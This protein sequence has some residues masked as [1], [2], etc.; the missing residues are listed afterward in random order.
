MVLFNPGRPKTTTGSG[1]FPN[2]ITLTATKQEAM[3][4]KQNGS[5]WTYRDKMTNVSLQNG[6]H[7]T[8]IF[9]EILRMHLNLNMFRCFI[10]FKSFS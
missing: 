2:R 6:C 5:H 7:T 1:N 3:L 8:M 9:T 10:Q 4:W